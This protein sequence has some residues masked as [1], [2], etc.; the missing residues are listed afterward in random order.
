MSLA[1]WAI[2]ITGI[3]AALGGAIAIGTVCVHY[4]LLLW[5]NGETARHEHRTRAFEARIKMLQ[6]RR[7]Y[8]LQ[9]GLSPLLDATISARNNNGLI[10]S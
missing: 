2:Q 9:V 7:E 1:D 6:T 10:P 3:V 5:Y 8:Y 4:A